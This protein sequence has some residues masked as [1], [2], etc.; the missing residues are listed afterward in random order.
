MVEI[1]EKNPDYVIK[2]AINDQKMNILIQNK[3]R[4]LL[5]A[6]LDGSELSSFFSY[7]RKVETQK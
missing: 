3:T 4:E 6:K 5:V 1:C 7:L 2:Q